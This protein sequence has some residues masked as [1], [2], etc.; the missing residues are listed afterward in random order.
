MT[1]RDGFP[2]KDKQQFYDG[3]I[4][5]TKKK[6]PWTTIALTKGMTIISVIIIILLLLFKNCTIVKWAKDLSLKIV[7]WALKGLGEFQL[8]KRNKHTP[9]KH[10]LL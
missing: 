1:G 3:V 8:K 4:S 5:A 7:Q 9:Y 6:S 10:G 2:W